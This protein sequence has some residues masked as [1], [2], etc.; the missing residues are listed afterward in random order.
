MKKN[1]FLK[2]TAPSKKKNR[3]RGNKMCARLASQLV[4]HSSKSGAVSRTNDGDPSQCQELLT[5]YCDLTYI[6]P[7]VRHH[8]DLPT[9]CG[10]I[11][12][13]PTSGV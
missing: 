7:R 4:S 10:L 8:S 6:H 12:F 9:A 3:N 2:K 5:I 1:N 11:S 13:R